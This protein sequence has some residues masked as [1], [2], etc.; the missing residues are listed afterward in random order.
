M[1]SSRLVKQKSSA[2]PADE[3]PF[4]YTPIHTWEL[5]DTPLRDKNIAAQAWI[6]APKGLLSS[7]DDL[8][9]VKIAYKRRID[10]WLLWRAGPARRSDARYIAVSLNEKQEIRTFR[11]FP[12][13]TGSGMGG[14]GET[15]ENFRA[16]KISLK[17]KVT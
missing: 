14:D 8:G 11:L 1:G 2:L 13:G 15:H 5:P 6:E 9:S 3:R 16:W 12:D 4:D 10:N 7:G 17:N